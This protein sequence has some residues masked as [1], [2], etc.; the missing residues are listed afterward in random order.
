MRPSP[1][2]PRCAVEPR[3]ARRLAVPRG[4]PRRDGRERALRRRV[5]ADALPHAAARD[6]LGRRHDDDLADHRLPTALAVKIHGLQLPGRRGVVFE[7]DP[8]TA[9]FV[10]FHLQGSM[11]TDVTTRASRIIVAGV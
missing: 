10:W 11:Q 1:R 8:K 5:R 7:L 2:P 9:L 3:G 4:A 6:A